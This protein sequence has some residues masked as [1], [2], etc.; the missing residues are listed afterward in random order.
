MQ[1]QQQQT[2]SRALDE[3]MTTEELSEYLKV[4]VRTLYGW[5]EKKMGPRVIRRGGFIRYKRS[6]V[7]AWLDREYVT[8]P[9]VV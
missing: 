7:E 9:K 3:L 4:T 8:K 5:I 2:Q 6:D 1:V